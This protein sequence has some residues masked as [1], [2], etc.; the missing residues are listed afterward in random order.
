MQN[1]S[2][3]GGDVVILSAA[4][5]LQPDQK[6][7][8]EFG[9]RFRGRDTRL[10]ASLYSPEDV[11]FPTLYLYSLPDVITEIEAALSRFTEEDVD[12]D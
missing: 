8:C 12:E 3:S 7:V 11:A 1:N 2:K 6:S 10:I 9:V 4:R 5:T